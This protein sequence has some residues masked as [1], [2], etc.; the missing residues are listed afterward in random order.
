[1]S[2][3]VFGILGPI[4]LLLTRDWGM[5]ATCLSMP[6][7]PKTPADERITF[8][9]TLYIWI[10]EYWQEQDRLGSWPLPETAKHY[11][12]SPICN[13]PIYSAV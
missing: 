5:G 1:M 6:C 8:V 9:D 12:T 4:K 3:S 13:L 11:T 7:L 10:L 2:R